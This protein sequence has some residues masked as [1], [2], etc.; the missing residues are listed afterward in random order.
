M[1]SFID[2]VHKVNGF[3]VLTFGKQDVYYVFEKFI[4]G[5]HR[6]ST[7]CKIKLG[8]VERQRVYFSDG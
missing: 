1:R 2:S 6:N 5:D 7:V 8:V 3:L 4:N